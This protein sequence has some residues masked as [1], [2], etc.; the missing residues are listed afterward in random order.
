MKYRHLTSKVLQTKEIMFL[1]YGTEEPKIEEKP[2]PI[3]SLTFVAKLMKI[4]PG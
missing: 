2:T 1:R 4:T 3:L